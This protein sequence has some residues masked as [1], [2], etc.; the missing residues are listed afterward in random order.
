MKA[1]EQIDAWPCETAAVAVVRAEGTVASRGPQD[2]VFRWAS[3]TKLLTAYAVLVAAEEGVL[4]LDEPAGPAGSTLR[5]LLA[6][7]SGLPFE[8][9]LPIAKPGERRIYSNTGFDL[10]G[11]LLAERAEMPF[12]SYLQAAVPDP[13]GLAGSELRGRPSEGIWGPLTDLAAFGRELLAPTLVAPETLAEATAVAFPGLVGVLP[14]LGRQEPN[15]WGLGFELK[16][17][18]RPHWTGEDNSPRTFGHFGGAGTFLWVDP[19]AR[20]ACACLTDLEFDEWA[21]A[22]WPPLADAILAELPALP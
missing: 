21:L 13:L 17:A 7:A 8:G 14:G 20:V 18:K 15:D 19:D 9:R 16:D 1:L 22:A 6:H 4:D 5:H 12:V 10:A 2:A 3:V 11:E